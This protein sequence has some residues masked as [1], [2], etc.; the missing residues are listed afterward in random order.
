MNDKI[1]VFKLDAS[2]RK[3]VPMN[4]PVLNKDEMEYYIWIK[5]PREYIYFY[6]LYRILEIG[7]HVTPLCIFNFCSHEGGPWYRIVSG[8]LNQHPGYHIYRMQ[9]VDICTNETTSLYF[10]YM[11]QDDSPDKPYL[12]MDPDERTCC[13]NG[14]SIRR[15]DTI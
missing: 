1:P 8:A 5:V 13:C 7:E 9:F 12:Y 15:L 4:T 3:D 11:L 2:V 14:T 6:R 10:A